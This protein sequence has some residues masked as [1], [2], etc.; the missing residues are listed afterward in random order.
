[1]GTGPWRVGQ[2]SSDAVSSLSAGSRGRALAAARAAG[3][4]HS[5]GT[6]RWVKHTG[7][8][9]TPFY[10][11][12]VVGAAVSCKLN[13]PEKEKRIVFISLIL[14]RKLLGSTPDTFSP[15]HLTN[16]F[17]EKQKVSYSIVQK[18]E[19]TLRK[20]QPHCCITNL[21]NQTRKFPKRR[22]FCKP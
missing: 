12:S 11:T 20:L 1:M 5:Q 19:A 7:L 15:S 13:L 14:G 8:K 4:H 2:T 10:V 9:D 22:I 17:L 3:T 6:D 18:S 21:E 16:T